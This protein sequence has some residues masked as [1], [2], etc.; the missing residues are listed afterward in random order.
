VRTEDE[1]QEEEEEA[2]GHVE[3]DSFVD[4]GREAFAEHPTSP[5]PPKREHS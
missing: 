3:A 5:H 1:E 4:G 2:Y